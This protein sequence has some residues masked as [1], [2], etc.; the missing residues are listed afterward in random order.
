[1]RFP[2]ETQVHIPSKDK[3]L[4]LK[5]A[6]GTDIMNERSRQHFDLQIYDEDLLIKV[7]S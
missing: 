7:K 3:D 1:M 6:A 5:T 4:S 2:A